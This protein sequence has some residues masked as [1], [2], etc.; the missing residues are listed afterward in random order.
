VDIAAWIHRLGMQQYEEGFA[1]MK[2]TPRCCR[3]GRTRVSRTLASP[4][5]AAD[6]GCLGRSPALNQS[7]KAAAIAPVSDGTPWAAAEQRQLMVMFCDLVGSTVLFTICEKLSPRIRGVAG[8]DGFFAKRI[9]DAIS[10]LGTHH[11]LVH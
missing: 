6:A 2:S 1:T 9:I 11:L 8:F 4:R 10:I 5:S 3:A 7:G